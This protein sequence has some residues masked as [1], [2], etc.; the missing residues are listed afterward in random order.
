MWPR[1]NALLLA[2]L[3]A[4]AGHASGLACG[5]AYAA[6][7]LAISKAQAAALAQQRHGGEVLKVS[8]SGDGY[9]V[10]LLLPSGRVK[11]VRV[12]GRSGRVSG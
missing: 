12:D 9:Q 5:A 4:V 2:L 3:L 11:A 8:R 1:R 6:E 7:Q 10:K